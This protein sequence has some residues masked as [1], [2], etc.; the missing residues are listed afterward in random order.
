MRAKHKRPP[1]EHLVA[2][3]AFQRLVRG[4]ERIIEFDADATPSKSLD[5]TR[6]GVTAE[7]NV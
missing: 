6:Q 5:P 4:V 3:L 1:E 2:A 7:Q